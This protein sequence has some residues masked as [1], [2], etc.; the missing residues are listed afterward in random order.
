M[1]HISSFSDLIP[2]FSKFLI[3]FVK[4][5]DHGRISEVINFKG[6]CLRRK[7]LD[8]SESI[9]LTL[10]V[11]N[12]NKPSCLI[13]ILRNYSSMTHLII[14]DFYKSYYSKTKSFLQR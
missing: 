1:A 6:T 7:F 12:W 5:D 2:R 4:N 8:I 13:E 3:I 9:H 10:E 11:A 14:I